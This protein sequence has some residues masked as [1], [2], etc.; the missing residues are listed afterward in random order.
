MEQGRNDA[1]VL[2]D[3]LKTVLAFVWKSKVPHKIYV[4]GWRLLLERIL[5]RDLLQQT[6]IIED[7]DNYKCVFCNLEV[8][9]GN[10]LFIHCTVANLFGG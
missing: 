2:L 4:L 8:E 1:A 6:G 7:P 3:Y 10:H 5:T 9:S